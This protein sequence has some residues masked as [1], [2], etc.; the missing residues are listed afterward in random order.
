MIQELFRSLAEIFTWFVIV[1]PWEQAIRIR[2][3]KRVRLLTAGTYLRIPIVDRVYRQPTRLRRAVIP[4]QLITA[5]TGETIALS[6]SLGYSIEDLEML[7]QKMHDAQDTI[8]AEV[9]GL[10]A[11]YVSASSLEKCKPAAI[12]ARVNEKLQLNRYGLKCAGFMVIDFAV[13][14]TYRLING[15]LREWQTGRAIDTTLEIVAEKMRT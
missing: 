5:S 3:G 4:G 13:V 2:G 10:I 14:K 6:G 12:E 15:N 8:Q 1:A 11:E 7:Y 9:S